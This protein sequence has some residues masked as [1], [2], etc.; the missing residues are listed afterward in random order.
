[1]AEPDFPVAMSTASARDATLGG[2]PELGQAAAKPADGTLVARLLLHTLLCKMCLI[3]ALQD[4]C[5]QL[6]HETL[7]DLHMCCILATGPTSEVKFSKSSTTN[8]TQEQQ[9]ALPIPFARTIGVGRKAP[10]KVPRTPAQLAFGRSNAFTFSPAVGQRK[11]SPVFVMG[12]GMGGALAA[13]SPVP[14]AA[15]SGLC[16][17]CW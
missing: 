11:F 14:P 6:Q 4:I 13:T 16:S 17:L 1:M 5:S 12:A 15:M 8:I 7:V 2:S 9:A 10:R 3:T